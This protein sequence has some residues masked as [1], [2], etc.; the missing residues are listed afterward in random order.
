MERVSKEQGKVTCSRSVRTREINMQ[1][2]IGWDIGGAHLKATRLEDGRVVK[3]AQVACPL[4]LGLDELHR[5][6]A[7]AKP[8]VG[9]A[10]LNGADDD[11]GTLRCLRLARGGRQRRC[12]DRRAGI[13]AGPRALLR[14]RGRLR[15]YRRRCR[16]CGQNRLGQLACERRLRGD[17]SRNRALRRHGFDDDGSHPDH[18][19]KGEDARLFRCV[20]A[21]QWRIGLC[22]CRAQLFDVVRPETRALWRALGCL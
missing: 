8:L 4:W 22:R 5:A 3:V 15:R 17:P 13:G 2:I 10:D 16:A 19:R 6:F 18:W 12:R 21:R 20:A 7:E 14:R 1:S 11:G 9:S